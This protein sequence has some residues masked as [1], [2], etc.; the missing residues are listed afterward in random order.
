MFG[1]GEIIL[2]LAVGFLLFG[3]QKMPEIGRSVGKALR[4]LH[5][6]RDEFMGGID[7]AMEDKDPPRRP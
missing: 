7:A 6:V 2:I 1:G 3:P 5:K 4:E